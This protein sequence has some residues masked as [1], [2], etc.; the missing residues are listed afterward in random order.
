[1]S[2]RR[3]LVVAPHLDDEV[4]GAGGS[5]ARW[6]ARGDEVTVAVVTRGMPPLYDD[7]EEERC[8]AEARA[9]H[10]RLGIRATRFLDFPAGALDGCSHRELNAGL[11]D[12]VGAWAPDEV[13]LPFPGDLHVDHQRVF[14][15]GLVAVR[16]N[17]P[18]YP[19][20]VYAYETLSE[21]NWNAPFLTPS[22]IPNRFVD[23][24]AFLEAKLRAMACYRSQLAPFPGERSLQALEALAVLRGATVGLAAAEAFVTIRTIN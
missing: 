11:V 4:L 19:A 16:P 15:A 18:G 23:I 3:I 5:M 6:A 17:R 24:S 8:R 1:M 7:A 20:A 14:Q 10:D 13:Y 9:A 2:P 22:F 21:T 12:C